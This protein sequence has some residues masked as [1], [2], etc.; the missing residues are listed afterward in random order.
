MVL[1]CNFFQEY[2]FANFEEYVENSF[3][4][5][6]SFTKLFPYK[7]S[8]PYLDYRNQDVELKVK[9]FNIFVVPWL[10]GFLQPQYL[11]SCLFVYKM[12]RLPI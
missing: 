7:V 11:F 6:C 1:S 8:L 9:V 3:S 10:S 5:S 12:Y 2:G 4:V